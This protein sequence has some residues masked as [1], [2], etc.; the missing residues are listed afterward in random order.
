MTHSPH[1]IIPRQGPDFGLDGDIPRYW[2]GGDVFKTRFFDAMSLLFP[3][4]E[5]YFIV[6]VR[7]YRDRITDPQLAAEVRDFIYQ[8]G[9]HGMVHTRFN[10]RLR[11]QGIAVDTVL[12]KQKRVMFGFFRKY[13]PRRFTLAQ[14][15]A[16]EHMTALMAHGFFNNRMFADADPRIRAM[17]AWHAVEEI[18]HKAVAFDVFKKVARGGYFTRVLAMMLVSFTFPFHVFAIMRHMFAVDGVQQRFRVWIKG[19]WW[20]YGPGGLYPRLMP[21]YLA[22]FLPGFH[23]WKHGDLA[24][25][26]LW[27]EQFERH[28][29]DAVKAADAVMAAQLEATPA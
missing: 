29:G 20:L 25:Y 11:E 5:K 4:G 18:E 23:P 1:P 15:A 7:D 10:D 3:E 8:E 28:Q 2:F 12:D 26:R 21:S 24:V 22:Y 6:C 13:F 19:L 27:N 16:A 9:Q 17:Y 14:T